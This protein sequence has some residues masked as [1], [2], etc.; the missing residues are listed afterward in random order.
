MPV[1]HNFPMVSQL[2]Q[3]TSDGRPSENAQFD[4]V[5]AAIG[6]AILWYQGKSQWDDTVNPDKMKDQAYGEGLRNSGT[7]ATAYI[8]FC[9]M[10]GCRLFPFNGSPAEL[11]AEI[12]RQITLEHPVIF[13]EPDPYV[14]NS[15]GW[16]HVCV[17]YGEGPGYLMAMD[18]YIARPVH[19][20]DQEWINLLLYNQ[21]WIV[22]P[23]EVDVT[24]DIKT[25][26]VSEHFTEDASGRWTCKSN[27]K[28]IHGGILEFYKS[29]G[30]SDLNGLTWLGIPRSF[31]IPLQ[32]RGPGAVKQFFEKA[33]VEWS[34]NKVQL[35][36]LY[37]GGPGTDPRIADYQ[38]QI[39]PAKQ[40]KIDE[41]KTLVAS[42]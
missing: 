36:P 11:V 22:E 39:D 33:V 25:P 35:L 32:G 13:T 26:G 7:A 4:C 16:S 37:D 12:H 41:L 34:N 30:N 17:F 14:S 42:L 1:L 23:L 8:D 19:R 24:I 28:T 29:F 20:N 3:I 27:G 18:P 2:T 5:P 40:K 6:A 21:I 38:K 10:Q 9:A 31:E 15:Y